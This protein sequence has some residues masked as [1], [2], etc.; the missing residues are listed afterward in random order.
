LPAGLD[1]EAAAFA[2]VGAIAMQGVRQAEIQLGHRVGVL[3]LGLLGQLTVQIL[4]ASGAK[5]ICMDVSEDKM[6]LARTLGSDWI[7]PTDQFASMAKN[8]SDGNGLDSVIITASTSSNQ[9]VEL[10]G[11]ACRYKGKVVVVGMVGMDIPRNEYYRKEIDLRLSMSY[12]PGRYDPLYEEKG[13]DYPY[14]LVRFTE[15]RNMQTFIELCA[16]GKVTPGKLITHRFIFTDAM[17]AYELFDGKTGE[18]YLGILLKYETEK[19]LSAHVLLPS[20]SGPRKEADLIAGLVGA[21]N[22]AKGV[23]LPKL[24]SMA[25]LRIEAI[26]TATGASAR[27]TAEK[28]GIRKIFADSTALLDEKNINTVFITTRHNHHASAVLHALQADKHVFVEKPLCLR[29]E[30]LTSIREAYTSKNPQSILM[31]GFNRRFSQHALKLKEWVDATDER[32]VIRYR[33]NG[34]VIP[35]SSWIQDPDI[36]GGRIIGEVCH[37]VDFCSFLAGAGVEDVFAST[38][39][40]QGDYNNDNVN[41]ILRHSNGAR[42]SI[43]YLANGDPSLPKEQIEVFSGRG[44]ATCEDFRISTFSRGSKKSKFKS[45]G[46][47]KGF[48][49]ELAAFCDAVLG[50]KKSP[51]SF[52]SIANTTLTTFR[53][54]ESIASNSVRRV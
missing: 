23:L 11:E 5:V 48:E 14:S 39:E 10:A 44:I 21:G 38:L 8:F 31:V 1:T 25:N 36:G 13:I 22:F 19:P 27:G 50:K 29:E 3:G 16:E 17:K 6:E 7:A 47:D 33:V 24:G 42:S 2:T 18:P 32:P 30:E 20:K 43:D 51:I 46:M 4:K 28:Y 52:E 34:G 35:K 40:S 53:I 12:G 26:A 45:S 49:T 37:F 15:G 9:P 54:V 41:V